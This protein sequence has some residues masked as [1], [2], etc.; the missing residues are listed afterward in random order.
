MSKPSLSLLGG[1]AVHG[2]PEPDAEAILGQ[3]KA[4]AMLAYLALAPAGKYQRRDRLAALLW[5]EQDQTNARGALR[6]AIKAARDAF[7]NAALPDQSD[8]DILLDPDAVTCDVRDFNSLVDAGNPEA[9]LRIY[10]GELMPGFHVSG[11]GEFIAWL[12][13]ER[14]AVSER[15]AAA[16]W[17]VALRNEK[18]GQ[19]TLA[20]K[21]ARLVV[22]WSWS[23]ERHLR[24]VMQLLARIGDR[25]GAIKAYENSKRRMLAELDILPSPETDALA[26]KIRRGESYG[27]DADQDRFESR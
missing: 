14:A 25:A 26:A 24:R 22:K 11:C 23:D 6:K 2:V 10:E 4:L 12:D 15:A 3:G 9:A 27:V 1:I 16:A 18:D 21:H 7:G 13:S 5:P 20:G 19:G 8:H 17:A